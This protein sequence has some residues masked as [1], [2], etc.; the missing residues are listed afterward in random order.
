MVSLAENPFDT[1][2]SAHRPIDVC[3]NADAG[4]FPAQA[5]L[6]RGA[7]HFGGGVADDLHCF[8]EPL[9]RRSRGYRESG[10]LD[11]SRL[12]PDLEPRGIVL[13]VSET[14]TAGGR[15]V[16]PGRFSHRHALSAGGGRALRGDLAGQTLRQG[17]AGA[18]LDRRAGVAIRGAVD[19]F[20]P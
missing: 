12:S 13:Q 19:G 1:V 10:A 5:V 20:R 17:P 7:G 16:G 6:R 15:T 4:F 8:T 9:R 2:G 3:A 18:V 14:K 11:A